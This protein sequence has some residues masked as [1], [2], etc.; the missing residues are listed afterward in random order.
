MGENSV[1][2]S[3]SAT[4][5]GESVSQDLSALD[6]LP[7]VRRRSIWRVVSGIIVLALLALLA[8]AFANAK[9]DWHVVRQYLFVHAMVVG[10]ERTMILTV[11]AMALGL[12]L[13]VIGGVCITVAVFRSVTAL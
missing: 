12:I 10:A 11:G 6:S 5:G 1:I 2:G 4:T 7:R 13:G 8:I 3:N 9:I